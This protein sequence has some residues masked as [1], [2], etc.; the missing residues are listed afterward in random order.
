MS[1]GEKAKIQVSSVK[2]K[3]GNPVV[4]VPVSSNEFAY[5]CDKNDPNS[6]ASDDDGGCS[7]S[8]LPEDN[9]NILYIAL[10]AFMA[11]FAAAFGFSSFKK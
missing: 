5:E 10:A 1:V 7:V 11:I 4:E 8:E 9:T 6:C 3:S 2:V